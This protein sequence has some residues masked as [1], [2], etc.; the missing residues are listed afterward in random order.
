MLAG[1]D[2]ALHHGLE[3][4]AGA[5]QLLQALVERVAR[6][7]VAAGFLGLLEEAL[8][9]P[10]L[11]QDDEPGVEGH[12][13]EDDQRAPGDEVTLG[14]QLGQSVGVFG[15]VRRQAGVHGEIVRRGDIHGAGIHR[16][17]AVNR[18]SR[19]IERRCPPEWCHRL[20][21]PPDRRGP[22][23]V[24]VLCQLNVIACHDSPT[25]RSCRTTALPSPR[26]LREATG[27]RILNYQ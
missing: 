23:C 16:R 5:G 10:Q 12:Q 22:L 14:P 25:L 13:Q 20:P 1:L 15:L 26:N 8:L 7:E 3:H 6:P 21:E 24:R 2:A 4:V 19:G 11:G 17:G 18:S 9:F 27:S